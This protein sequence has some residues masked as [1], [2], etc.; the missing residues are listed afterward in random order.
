M[1]RPHEPHE[2]DYVVR[3]SGPERRNG[4]GNGDWTSLKA[5]ANAI[6][7]IGIP[8]AIAIYLVYIGATEMPKLVVNS[9][10]AIVEIQ[11]TRDTLRDHIVQTDIL[12]R[13][14]ERTCVGVAKDSDARARCLDK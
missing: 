11:K 4:I 1:P 5:W 14:I 2:S 10:Q 3:Y 9:S 8:G 7:I 6:G 13:A 12:I